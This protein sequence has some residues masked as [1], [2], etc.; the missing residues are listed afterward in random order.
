MI[1]SMCNNPIYKAKE[2]M[3]IYKSTVLLRM[4]KGN[5]LV[6]S[7]LAGRGEERGGNINSSVEKEG[8]I[9]KSKYEIFY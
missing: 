6:Q 4:T 8:K 5:D 7:L 9:W 2:Q 1:G 3:R